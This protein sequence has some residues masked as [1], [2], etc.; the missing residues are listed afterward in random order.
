MPIDTMI[1]TA[2]KF[3]KEI[4]YSRF[5]ITGSVALVKVWNVNLNR[6]LHDVDILI[7]GGDTDKEGHISYKRN[8]VKID[9]FLVRDFDVK[10][11]KIIED[12]EYVSD[13]QCIL[14]C[15]R[16]MGRDKDIKDIE[17][18]NSQLKIEK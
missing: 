13:L 7:Q 18:I 15:K 4:G 6:E 11:T 12:V 10:E 5:L 3:L 9:I 14:E 16:K 1:E 8:N 17:I 2:V